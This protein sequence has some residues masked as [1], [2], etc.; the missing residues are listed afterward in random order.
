MGEHPDVN[1]PKYLVA[2]KDQVNHYEDHLS[3]TTK[4]SL[5]KNPNIR[6]AKYYR[7][8]V[9]KGLLLL[10]AYKSNIP[11]A[12]YVLTAN[13]SHLVKT[14]QDKKYNIS[15]DDI[16]YLQ[17]RLTVLVLPIFGKSNHANQCV[18]CA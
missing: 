7:R 5:A 4:A 10:V 2:M 8:L 11:N 9:D 16:K 1:V 14:L 6:P 3:R 15:D 17:D 18:N 12:T 13:L